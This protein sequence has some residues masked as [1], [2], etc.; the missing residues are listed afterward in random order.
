MVA[1]RARAAILPTA[2]RHGWEVYPAGVVSPPVARVCGL[3][4]VMRILVIN[5]NASVEM[6]DVMRE[7]LRAYAES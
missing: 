4:G 2:A 7:Q 6:S 1:H 3:R 5:P